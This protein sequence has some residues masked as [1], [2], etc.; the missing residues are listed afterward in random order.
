MYVF[1][2]R[3]FSACSR[4]RAEMTAAAG[5]VVEGSTVD[6]GFL[7]TTKVVADIRAY[8]ARGDVKGNLSE[9]SAPNVGVDGG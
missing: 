5:G 8:T 9:C 3:I 4:M 7:G 1:Q 6:P 2:K